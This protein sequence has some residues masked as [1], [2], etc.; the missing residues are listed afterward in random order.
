M[1]HRYNKL[2]II[3]STL[4]INDADS[5][6]NNLSLTITLKQHL[7]DLTRDSQMLPIQGLTGGLNFQSIFFATKCLLIET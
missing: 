6:V 1:A 2:L 7:T 5:A 3:D 4:P